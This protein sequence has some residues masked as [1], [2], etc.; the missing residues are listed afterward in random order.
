[1]HLS[2]W[3]AMFESINVCPQLNHMHLSAQLAYIGSF[4]WI[5]EWHDCVSIEHLVALLR[6]YNS[7][8][9]AQQAMAGMRYS[10]SK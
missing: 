2:A 8:S 5:D 4:R 10:S 9:Q 3:A 6:L 7:G 1:M